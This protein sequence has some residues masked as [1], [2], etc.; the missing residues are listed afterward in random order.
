MAHRRVLLMRHAQTIPDASTDFER[1]LTNQGKHDARNIPS[2]IRSHGW[3]P[4]RII[5]SSSRRTMETVE[6]LAEYSEIP[7]EPKDELYLAPSETILE[8]MEST[9]RDETLLLVTH[10]PGCEVVLYQI[11]GAYHEMTPGACAFLSESNGRWAC[12]RILRPD[13]VN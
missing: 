7:T 1:S 6:L 12:E 5:L 2:S 9:R 4:S 11:T 3:T 10:N 13:E 8:F